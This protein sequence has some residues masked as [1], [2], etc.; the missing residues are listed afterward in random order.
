MEI[1]TGYKKEFSTIIARSGVGK[2]L[3]A[4][5]LVLAS[6][7]PSIVLDEFEQ[8]DHELVFDFTEFINAFNNSDFRES[9]YKYKKSIV[10]RLGSTPLN[11]FFDVLVKSKNFH[12]LLVFVD[13]IDMSLKSAVVSNDSGFYAFL[14]RG[15]H[16][17]FDLITTCRN[18]ANVPKQLIGQTDFFYF[19]E[20]IEKGAIDFVD[21]TLKGLDISSTIK[22]LDKY[23]FLKVNVNTKEIET[24]KTDINWLDY[25]N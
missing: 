21:S 19:S 15:R 6:D 22:E 2:T 23:E 9:F 8:F 13:E 18:T 20:L 5:L 14:N 25:F 12:D 16:F 4:H 17:N 7:K 10:L 1:K 3:L 24:F 11:T